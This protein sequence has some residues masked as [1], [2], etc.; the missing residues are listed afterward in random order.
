MHHLK[1]IF[2]YFYVDKCDKNQKTENFKLSYYT[3]KRSPNRLEILLNSIPKLKV[4]S[5]NKLNALFSI[6]TYTNPYL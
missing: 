2:R 5:F 4:A 6:I 3:L 1:F